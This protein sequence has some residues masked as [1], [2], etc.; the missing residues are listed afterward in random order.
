M[1]VEEDLEGYFFDGVIHV[2][3]VNRSLVAVNTEAL[4]GIP[5]SGSSF[6]I[7]SRWLVAVLRPRTPEPAIQEQGNLMR[8]LDIGC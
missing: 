2:D 6:P 8:I 4:H 3:T 7:K 1:V 5:V